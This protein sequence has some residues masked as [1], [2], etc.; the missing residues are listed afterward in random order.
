[1]VLALLQHGASVQLLDGDGRS[2]LHW[3]ASG[4]HDFILTTLLHH[5]L[6]VDIMDETR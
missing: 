6:E 4:G 5:G 3:A 1:M 2:C